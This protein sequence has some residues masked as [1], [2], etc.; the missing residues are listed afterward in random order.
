[1][2]YDL[3]DGKNLDYVGPVASSKGW[4]DVMTHAGGVGTHA[5]DLLSHGKCDHPGR[6]AEEFDEWLKRATVPDDVRGT[7]ENLVVLLKSSKGSVTISD[8]IGAD[9]ETTKA[10]SGLTSKTG[11]NF[12]DLR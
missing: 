1:M 10:S 6:A 3:Y 7:I 9:P 2:A 4:S 5:A 12:Y 11:F 8:G